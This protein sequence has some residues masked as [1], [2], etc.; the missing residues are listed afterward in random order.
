MLF[1]RRAMSNAII[2]H[3]RRRRRSHRTIAESEAL[4]EY[5]DQGVL[6]PSAMLA[7]EAVVHESVY[8][9]AL[10]RLPMSYQVP[11]TLVYLEGCPTHVAAERLGLTP[12]NLRTRLHRGLN[13]MRDGIAG[14]PT[15]ATAAV[16]GRVRLR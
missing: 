6:D 3:Y 16:Y 2:D 12:A 15:A 4:M 10:R 5:L 8:I 7:M 1:I 9:A 11:I 14:M 13:Q